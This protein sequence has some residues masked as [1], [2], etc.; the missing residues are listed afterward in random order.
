MHLFNDVSIN[1]L[2]VGDNTTLSELATGNFL[3]SN[4]SD[5]ITIQTNGGTNEKITISNNQGDSLESI[6]IK[7]TCGRRGY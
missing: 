4:K 7:S 2:Q 6:L 3:I 5:G 1:T